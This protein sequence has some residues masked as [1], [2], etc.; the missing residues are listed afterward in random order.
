M[1]PHLPLL[2]AQVAAITAMILH[3][4]ETLYSE[5]AARLGKVRD[6]TAPEPGE[7]HAVTEARV[8]HLEHHL[9]RMDAAGMVRW[10]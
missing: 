10:Q 1:F 2:P 8:A 7:S 4:N 5:I 6:E 9:A 3:R